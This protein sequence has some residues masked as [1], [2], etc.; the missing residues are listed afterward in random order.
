MAKDYYKILGIEK[1]AS[2]DE[3]KKAFRALAHKTHPDKQGGDEAKFKEINEAYQVLSDEKKRTQYDQFGAGAFDGSGGGG[4]GGGGFSAGGGFGGGGYNQGGFDFSGFQQADFGDLGDMF[5]DFFG[6]G[7]SHRTQSKKGSDIQVDVQLSFK[8]SVFGVEK[9]IILTKNNSCERCGGNGAEPAKG[10]KKC[11]V[12][13]GHGIVIG[14]QRTILGNMQTKRACETCDGSG[15]IPNAVCIT[16]RGSGVEKKRKTITVSIPAGVE[17]G[18]VLRVRN[19]GEAIKGGVTGDLFVRVGV[20]QDSRFER[21]GSTIFSEKKIGF[22]QAALGDVVSV[23][24]VEGKVD[25][26]I[27]AG[28]QSGAQFRLRGKGVQTER[29]RGDQIVVVNIVTPHKLSKE[30]KKMLEELKLNE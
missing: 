20:K 11:S 26:T 8:E 28:T 15:E 30:Q 17:N 24:T 4:Y 10:T 25:L 6:G 27:P 3:I 1:S 12:C 16:C 18:N 29:G 19:E 22:T 23:E 13:D 14:I 9:E 21:E 5:G 2:Q 7:R